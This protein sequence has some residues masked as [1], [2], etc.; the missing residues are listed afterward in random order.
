MLFSFVYF[1]F[2]VFGFVSWFIICFCFLTFD[3]SV[4]MVILSI[5]VLN[6][7]ILVV[8][9]SFDVFG[10]RGMFVLLVIQ[11]FV[12]SFLMWFGLVFFYLGSFLSFILL[13]SLLC[14]LYSMPFGVIYLKCVSSYDVYLMRFVLLWLFTVPFFFMLFSFVDSF[15]ISF[16]F[17][18]LFLIVVVSF[19]MLL[20]VGSVFE[21]V[22]VSFG[23]SGCLVV[24]FCLVGS[25][26]TFSL[27]VYL[28][29]F[30]IML[31]YCFTHSLKYI[32]SLFFKFVFVIVVLFF[33][34]FHIL[35]FWKFSM[36]VDVL[37]GLS[38]GY[39][40]SFVFGF[41]GFLFFSY[42][43]YFVFS[44]IVWLNRYFILFSEFFYTP[45]CSF[46][47][48]SFWFCRQS[49]LRFFVS[50]LLFVVFVYFMFCFV[51]DFVFV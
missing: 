31:I 6:L 23:F 49:S 5:E 2:K 48:S 12:L 39:M 18:L 25:D 29:L 9:F 17:F 10:K 50:F 21:L 43:S 8:L 11:W 3:N 36:L 20:F 24:L 32:Y 37:G 51:F 26:V 45:S 44:S 16:V 22:V 35:L 7:F 33:G 38:N 42:C 47:F 27:F 34:G 14:K 15:D 40:Y 46:V 4:N 1:F 41:E 30:L 28:F 19:F 13:F